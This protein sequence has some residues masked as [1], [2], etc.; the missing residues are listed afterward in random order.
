MKA[1]HASLYG[2]EYASYGDGRKEAYD[3]GFGATSGKGNVY[4]NVSYVNEKET[5]AGD[6]E[7]SAVP[8]FWYSSWFR[9]FFWYSSQPFHVR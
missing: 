8:I 1:F 9:W 4:V 3:I 7:I 2:S 5:L 6:R